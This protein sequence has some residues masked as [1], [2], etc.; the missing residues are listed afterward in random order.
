MQ[1]Q[2]AGRDGQ[3]H[4]GEAGDQAAEH[5]VQFDAGQRSTHAVPRAVAEGQVTDRFSRDVEGIGIG[6]DCPVAVG[7]T[8][9]EQDEVSCVH[10]DAV[11]HPRAAARRE[12]G[13]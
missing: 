6:E 8:R 13:P 4:R 2:L 12:R 11:Q 10:G 5:R 3:S 9:V 7:C 1:L